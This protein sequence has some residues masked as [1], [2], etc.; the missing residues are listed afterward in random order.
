MARFPMRTDYLILGIIR[1]YM[2]AIALK[3]QLPWC[4]FIG[5]MRTRYTCTKNEDEHELCREN[6]SSLHYGNN[7]G[8]DQHP[9]QHLLL[10]AEIMGTTKDQTS[11]MFSICC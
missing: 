6:T 11:I 8:A 10:V 1:Q 4:Y 2:D 9:V 3:T 5:T 7:K